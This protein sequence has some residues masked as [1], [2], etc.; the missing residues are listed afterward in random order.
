MNKFQKSQLLLATSLLGSM[1]G[2]AQAQVVY[3]SAELHGMGA[4]SIATIMPREMNCIGTG[5]VAD[6]SG[7]LV[8]LTSSGVELKDNSG[9]A[10]T[11]AN[12]KA[13]DNNGNVT[14]RKWGAYAGSDAAFDCAAKSIQPGFAGAYVSTGSGGGKSAWA[15]INAGTFFTGASGKIFPS[16]F[17]TLWGNPHFVMSDS[18]IS[19]GNLSSFNT[20]SA[21]KKAGAAIQFPLYVLPVALIYNP[22]YGAKVDASGNP[23]LDAS[24]NPIQYKFNVGQPVTFNGIATG[25]L[26]MSKKLYCSVFNGY[27]TNFND[28]LFTAL[29][30]KVVNKKTTAVSLMDAADSTTRWNND[31]VPIRLV[32]RLDKSGTTDIFTRHLAAACSSVLPTGKANK[33]TQAAEA[34]PYSTASGIDLT[35][36]RSDSPYKPTTTDTLSGTADMISGAYWSGSAL[37]ETIGTETIGKFTVADGSSRLESYIKAAPDKGSASDSTVKLNGRLGYVGADFVAPSTG[38]FMHAAALEVADTNA[39]KKPLWAMP[40]AA[41]AQAAFGTKILPPEADKGGKYTASGTFKRTNPLDWYLALY[42]GDS[43]LANPVVGYPITGTTQFVSGTCFAKPEVRN[44][45]TFMLTTLFGQTKLDST[46]GKVSTET[47]T[48]VKA[49]KLGIRPQAGLAP[50]PKAWTVAIT[51]TFLKRSKMKSSTG[52]LLSDLNLYIQ[53]GVPTKGGLAKLKGKT[54]LAASDLPANGE[55]AVKDTKGKSVAF[56]EGTSNSTCTAGLGL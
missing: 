21:T 40:T 9:N 45:L 36:V 1:A 33:Y 29:N 18:P 14:V 55:T 42:D 47:F 41:D 19:S 6:A 52:S 56:A 44:A 54:T 49:A 51:E 39:S 46:G 53:N 35:S 22:V 15:A 12:I 10:I 30:T 37:V 34:L 43:T 31:G 27:V 25:G 28:P 17:G 7:N 2:A 24:G 4:S 16:A 50:L 20:A 5:G 32:G 8:N 3:P 48:G 26:R 11:K 23:V 38:L 13:G